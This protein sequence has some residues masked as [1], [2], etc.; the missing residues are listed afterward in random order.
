MRFHVSC[1]LE[2]D[3]SFPST[4]ILNMHAQ[5]NATQTILEERFA[6]EP[7]TKV[8]EFI[9]DGNFNRF[10]RLETGR[11]KHLAIS[12]SATVDC[13]HEVIAAKQDRL[14]AG[15]GDRSQGDSVFV[16]QPLLPIGSIGP[17]G[18][19]SV[20]QDCKS[21]REGRAHR[22]LDSCKC[23]VCARGRRTRRHRPTTRSRSEPA[24]AAILRTLGIAL[25]RALNISARY[26]SGYAYELEPPIFMLAS[27]LISA[28]AG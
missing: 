8:D 1:D 19:G 28:V 12:Y 20:W 17:P 4:L 18:V 27:K 7:R 26:F 3:V 25:C 11:K 21:V 6:V 10:V 13:S 15:R 24:C 16:S 9:A 14:H 2:Y 23:G 22:R 5:R